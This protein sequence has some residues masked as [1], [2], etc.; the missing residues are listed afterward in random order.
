MKRFVYV[1]TSEHNNY[2]IYDRMEK[3]LIFVHP[4]LYSIITA[5]SMNKLSIDDSVE[6]YH[7]I[8][9]QYAIDD[10]IYYRDKYKYWLSTG[11]YAPEQE[12]NMNFSLKM[13]PANIRSQLANVD[14]IVFEVTDRCNLKCYYCGYGQLYDFY[15]ARSGS[16]L[17]REMAFRLIDYMSELWN[18]SAYT[19]INKEVCISFYGGEPLLNVPL[20]QEII[21]YISSKKLSEVQFYYSMTTNGVLLKKY[22]DFL[23]QHD[24]HLLISLDGDRLNNSYRTFKNNRASFDLVYENVSFLRNK[25]PDYFK[26]RVNFNSVLHNRNTVASIYNFVKNEFDKLPRIGELN[27]M[28][29]REDAKKEFYQTYQNTTESLHQ[30]EDYSA[31]EQNMF[32][33][34]PDIKSMVYFIH[35]Y[36]GNVYR[37]YNDLF[38]DENSITIFP[39]GTCFPFSRKLFLTTGGKILQCERI[40]HKYFLGTVNEEGVTIDFEEIAA[41]FEFWYSKLEKQCKHCLRLGACSQCLFYVEKLENSPKCPGYAN[42]QTLET[43]LGSSLYHLEETPKEYARITNEISIL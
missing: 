43:Q 33:L 3:R 5:C 42:V 29:V 35:R 28:G 7:E 13:D 40:A 26:K 39:T 36:T 34:L 6:K 37:E 31:I 14:Q 22:S 11:L 21:D 19:S 30:Q 15:D 38:I 18:S 12:F 17:N 16:E 1:R 32:V 20:I 25:Y 24:F 41:K 8:L 27:T 23:M 4:I 10:L 2:Y 9:H